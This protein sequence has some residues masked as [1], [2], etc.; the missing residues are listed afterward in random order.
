MKPLIFSAIAGA[1]L[2]VISGPLAAQNP[3]DV[4]VPDRLSQVRDPLGPI[5]AAEL[6]TGRFDVPGEPIHDNQ[7]VRFAIFDRLEWQSGEGEPGFLYD[8]FGFVGGD[9]NRLWF[10][11]EGEGSFDEGL[12]AAEVQ[13]LYNRA[14]T[15]Y[16][17]LQVGLR[18]DFKP[19]PELS[20]AV[21]GFEGL[22]TY[23]TGIEAN[24]YVSED[25]DV[26]GDFEIEYD[27][28]L[29]QR[30]V[31]QPRFEIAAQ[32]QDVAKLDLGSGI[33]NYEVGLRLRYEIRREFAPYVGVSWSE[34]V[35]DTADLLP[36]GEDTGTFSVVAGL[37]VW[38]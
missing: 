6:A 1:A 30:L 17:N 22:N 2:A 37:R 34:T 24:L 31:L 9:Y 7:I 25:G 14:I 10:E 23:W 27:E 3:P 28:F 13:V 18:H 4:V 33:T 12:D 20:Y 38:F 35:G 32:A 8:G 16:W 29:T 21:L 5:T 15:P 26:S 11:L 36:A 19:D